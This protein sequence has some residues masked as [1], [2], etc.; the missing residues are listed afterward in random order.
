MTIHH[1]DPLERQ[2]KNERFPENPPTGEHMAIVS[3]P[4]GHAAALSRAVRRVDVD[5]VS[6]RHE[7]DAPSSR[8]LSVFKRRGVFRG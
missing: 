1:S 8:R 6:T 4:P 2:G 7:T 5:L 3:L